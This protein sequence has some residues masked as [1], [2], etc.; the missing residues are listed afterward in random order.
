M[1][2]ASLEACVEHR[3]EIRA[4]TSDGDS[5]RDSQSALLSAGLADRRLVSKLPLCMGTCIGCF[6]TNTSTQ[7]RVQYRSAVD[8]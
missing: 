4:E 5:Y 2:V 6:C 3:V 8:N 1:E 7:L